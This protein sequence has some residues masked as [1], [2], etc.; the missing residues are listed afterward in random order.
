MQYNSYKD[1]K[2][3]LSYQYLKKTFNILPLYFHGFPR[4]IIRK[5]F[6]ENYKAIAFAL[7]ERKTDNYLIPERSSQPLLRVIRGL[8]YDTKTS[9]IE[10]AFKELN[11]IP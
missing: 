4:W 7:D 1:Q 11:F 3:W 2:A 8:N 5:N 9:D 10:E 6:P